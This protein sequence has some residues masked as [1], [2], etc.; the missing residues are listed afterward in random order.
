MLIPI[1]ISVGFLLLCCLILA[2]LLVLA[3]KKILNY[4]TC[5]IDVNSGK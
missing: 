4:G 5:H 1:L 3:E 2:G